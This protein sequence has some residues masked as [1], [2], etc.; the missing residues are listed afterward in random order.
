MNPIDPF[1]GQGALQWYIGCSGFHYDSWKEVFYPKGLAKSRWL[2]Y[3]SQHFNTIEINNTFY[4]PPGLR[5]LE[6]WYARTPPGFQITLKV[7]QQI[8]HVQRFADTADLLHAFYTAAADGLQEKLGCLLFQLPPSLAYDPELLN[9]MLAQL[10]TEFN[11]VIEFRHPSWWK[12]SVYDRLYREGVTFCGVSYPGLS[13]DL[14]SNAPLI[15]YRFHGVPKLYFSGY[16]DA[17]IARIVELIKTDP[18]ARKAYLYFNNTAEA[19]ALANARTTM[20][21]AAG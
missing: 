1:G 3:Y 19:A 17:Y 10:S 11:N 4:R 16:D 5:T 18:L 21:L 20:T 7:W 6:G 9:A 14:I 8:T 13:P 2:E 15:Y 12:P